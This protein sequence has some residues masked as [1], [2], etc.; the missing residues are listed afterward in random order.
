[1]L[2]L[3]SRGPG[4]IETGNHIATYGGGRENSAVRVVK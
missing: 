3:L 1:M 4:V 2:Y